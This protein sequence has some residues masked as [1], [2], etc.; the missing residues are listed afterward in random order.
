MSVKQ[1]IAFS[2]LWV[3][4]LCFSNLVVAKTPAVDKHLQ[5]TQTEAF[6]KA[7]YSL[8]KDLLQP[9]TFSRVLSEH[10]VTPLPLGCAVLQYD[11]KLRLILGY[12]GTT[13]LLVQD[14]D[15]C[16]S[17]SHFLFPYHFFW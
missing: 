13:V 16:E 15:R 5:D 1:C 10:S 6:L 9:Q 4:L 17:V 11:E 3:L 2:K 14:A 7:G 8:S 12:K